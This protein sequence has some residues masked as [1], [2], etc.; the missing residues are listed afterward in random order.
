[1]NEKLEAALKFHEEDCDHPACGEC[2]ASCHQ[3]CVRTHFD[4]LVVE[5][6]SI[7]D[8][9]KLKMEKSLISDETLFR[10]YLV[11][12]LT[13]DI[14][15]VGARDIAEAAVAEHR[16]LFPKKLDKSKQE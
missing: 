7:L 10:D 4:T 14:S 3:S 1:M 5:L 9:R 2:A 15:L 13:L 12:L 11:P 16:K 6:V 8:S